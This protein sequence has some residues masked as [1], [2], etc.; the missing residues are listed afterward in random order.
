M[1]YSKFIK[2]ISFI[3]LF[4]VIFSVFM[5]NFTISV[6]A[7]DEV[8][9]NPSGAYIKYTVDV[10]KKEDDSPDWELAY[11]FFN[12]KT[13]NYTIEEGDVIEYD[14]YISTDEGG[15]GH[16]DGNANTSTGNLRDTNA[17][18]TDGNGIHTGFDLSGDAYKDDPFDEW[19][20]RRLEIGDNDN[21]TGKTIKQFQ[22]AMHPRNDEP[23]YQ[24]YVLYDN[25]VI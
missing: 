25:I 23:E 19:Y 13:I 10:N 2:K 15:W 22:I 3:V 17:S 12:I 6:S 7:D 8:K 14:V 1:N 5:L 20:H 9:A 24:G 18:D 16:V 4:A 11:N 21:C